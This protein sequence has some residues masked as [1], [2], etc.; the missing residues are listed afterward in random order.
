MCLTNGVDLGS[1][2]ILVSPF[3]LRKLR[4]FRK[5][6]TTIR[7]LFLKRS[8]TL[9]GQ[10]YGASRRC[11]AGIFQK[12]PPVASAIP[13]MNH[14][15]RRAGMLIRTRERVLPLKSHHHA[16]KLTPDLTAMVQDSVMPRSRSGVIL[17]GIHDLISFHSCAFMWAAAGNKETGLMITSVESITS[18]GS[19]D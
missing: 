19:A 3:A 7:Q 13:L 5:R 16:G 11:L 4:C 10:R 8:L 2:R 1:F 14:A 9:V 18:V 6:K 17:S 15:I 12:Q